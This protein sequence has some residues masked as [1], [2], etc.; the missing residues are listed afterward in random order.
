MAVMET[1]VHGLQILSEQ[2]CVELLHSARLG[3]IALTHGALP[4]I[5]PVNFVCL[6]CEVI[7]S[8][9]PGVLARAA[10]DEQI[11]CF[12]SDSMDHDL[13]NAW[14]VSVIGRLS[15]VTEP[16]V[17]DAAQQLRLRP[18]TSQFT[19]HVRLQPGVYTGRRRVSPSSR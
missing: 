18:W 5:L 19:N 12:E 8:V 17:L 16:I 10:E 14:S 3:R 9:S 4:V 15:M 6:G 13:V 1:D 7:F 11:V 2:D